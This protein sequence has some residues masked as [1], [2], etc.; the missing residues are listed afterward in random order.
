MKKY[1]LILL[2]A[3]LLSGCASLQEAY[4]IDKEFGTLSQASWDKLVA[5]PDYR[6]VGLDVEGL[7]GITAEEVM[8]VHNKTFAKEPTKAEVFEFT[9]GTQGK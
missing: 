6:Y 9:L 5:Y 4:Y 3:I 1:G 7:E 2:S 8:A